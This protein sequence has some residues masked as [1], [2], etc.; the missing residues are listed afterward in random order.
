MCINLARN[1]N[2]ISYCS[3]PFSCSHYLS[4]DALLCT[5]AHHCASVLISLSLSNLLLLSFSSQLLS[6]VFIKAIYPPSSP[7]V[8]LSLC[9]SFSLSLSRSFSMSLSLY[10]SLAP[11]LWALE[12]LLDISPFP[13]ELRICFLLAAKPLSYWLELILVNKSLSLSVFQFLS[14]VSLSLSLSATL[15]LIPFEFWLFMT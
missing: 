6:L 4:F 1:W 12:Y 3:F 10:R 11:S 2:C 15:S 9:V 8:F 7:C 13:L 5:L 14:W